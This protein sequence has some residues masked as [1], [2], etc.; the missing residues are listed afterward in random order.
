MQIYI[1]FDKAD[2]WSLMSYKDTCEKHMQIFSNGR[3]NAKQLYSPNWFP[4]PYLHLLC[5]FMRLFSPH[6]VVF[7]SRACNEQDDAV[8]IPPIALFFS[9]SSWGTC[10]VKLPEYCLQHGWKSWGFVSFSGSFIWEGESKEYVV[11]RVLHFVMTFVRC[12][13]VPTQQVPSIITNQHIFRV[14]YF[15]QLAALFGI[16]VSNG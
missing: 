15:L 5:C 10:I 12:R 9:D 1:N 4:F 14:M 16:K 3:V 2:Q 6:T 7:T 11:L 8:D 13:V